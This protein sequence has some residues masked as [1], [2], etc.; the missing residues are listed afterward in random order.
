MNFVVKQIAI[1]YIHLFK[2]LPLR[3]MWGATSGQ[4]NVESSDDSTWE[5]GGATPLVD[6]PD[7]KRGHDD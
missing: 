5:R 6:P 4:V 7:G 3:G 1:I 2:V